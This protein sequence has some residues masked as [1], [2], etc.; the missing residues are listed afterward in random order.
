MLATEVEFE[1]K[2]EMTTVE[3][4]DPSWASESL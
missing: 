2:A 1:P 3:V 4:R